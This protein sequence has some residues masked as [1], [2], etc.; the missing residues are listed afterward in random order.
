M[1][2]QELAHKVAGMLTEETV[3]CLE[4]AIMVKVNSLQLDLDET[5]LK[6]SRM[7]DRSPKTS[8]V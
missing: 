3:G 8:I 1:G 4:K 7:K 2:S 5:K 6:L